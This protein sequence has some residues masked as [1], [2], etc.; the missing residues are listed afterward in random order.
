MEGVVTFN[1]VIDVIS[2]RNEIQDSHEQFQ[3]FLETNNVSAALC[4]TG[5]RQQQRNPRAGTVG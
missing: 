3:I 2:V 5:G 4:E 1:C